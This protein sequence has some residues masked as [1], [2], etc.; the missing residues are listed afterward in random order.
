MHFGEQFSRGDQ[1]ENKQ[2]FWKS[3]FKT[4]PKCKKNDIKSDNHPAG[5]R[6]NGDG[7][8]TEVYKCEHCDWHTSF[9]WDEAAETYYYETKYWK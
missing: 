4:C 9:Q 3:G 8:G 6:H 5:C 2:L 1:G 7:Y